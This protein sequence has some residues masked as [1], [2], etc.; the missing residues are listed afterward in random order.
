MGSCSSPR[1][2]SSKLSPTSHPSDRGQPWSSAT[3][4]E[5]RGRKCAEALPF[6]KSVCLTCELGEDGLGFEAGFEPRVLLC[7]IDVYMAA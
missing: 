4:F 2:H 1:E 6:G 3:Q 5:V 7:H